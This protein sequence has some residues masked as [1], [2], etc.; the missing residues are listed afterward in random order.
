LLKNDGKQSDYIQWTY[1]WKWL[2][3]WLDTN[4]NGMLGA[5]VSFSYLVFK[6]DYTLGNKKGNIRNKFL[7]ADAE[8]NSLPT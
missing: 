3:F 1:G 6:A 8:P 7:S 4:E 2:V 5:L